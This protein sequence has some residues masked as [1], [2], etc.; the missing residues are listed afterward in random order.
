MRP[1]RVTTESPINSGDSAD[2]RTEGS[3]QR[4]VRVLRLNLKTCYWDAIKDGS[5]TKEYR[6]ASK[7]ESKLAGKTYDEILLLKGYPKRGDETRQLRRSWN[8]YTV[9]T[10]T[11]PHFGDS[12]VKVLAID[13]AQHSNGRDRRPG[14]QDA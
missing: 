1:E 7:W 11:H 13:V 4:I 8:G 2:Q 10:I 3:H 14:P 5:K 9:E 6:L 12:P